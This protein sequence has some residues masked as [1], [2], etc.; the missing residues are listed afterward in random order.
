MDVGPL[1]VWNAELKSAPTKYGDFIQH[2]KVLWYFKIMLRFSQVEWMHHHSQ[3]AYEGL[4]L[5]TKSWIIAEVDTKNLVSR[6]CV[7]MAHYTCH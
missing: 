7:F 4:M 6:L 5:N 3:P 2:K 1:R